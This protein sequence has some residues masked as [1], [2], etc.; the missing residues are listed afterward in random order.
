MCVCVCDGECACVR[1]YMSACVC[2][3]VCVYALWLGHLQRFL[4]LGY[5]RKPLVSSSLCK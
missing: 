3:C 1:A 5:F 4:E 2:V